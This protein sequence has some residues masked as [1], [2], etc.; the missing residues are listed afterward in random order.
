[1]V[2]CKRIIT[3]LIDSAEIRSMYYD[4]ALDLFGFILSDQSVFISYRKDLL[5]N[6]DKVRFEIS[7]RPYFPLELPA[8]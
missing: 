6:V 5:S 1:M 4:H 2:T 7:E 3:F 8:T